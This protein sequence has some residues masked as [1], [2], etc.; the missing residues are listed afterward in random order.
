MTAEPT[1]APDA[2]TPL[3]KALVAIRQ[4]REKVHHLQQAAT[5]PIAIVGM[6]CRLPGADDPE[7]FWELLSDGRDMI[8][9]IPAD[10]WDIGA[11]YDPKPGQ[12]GKTYS[13]HG[14]FLSGVDR[15]D[16]AFF[17]ISAR[18]AE[19]MDPQQRL[20]LEV[21]WEALEHAGLIPERLAG[22]ATGV[23]IGVTSSD[24]GL[25]QVERATQE[26]NNPY[27]N[28]GTP[29]NA[30]AGRLSYILG[31]QGPCIAVDT[32]CSSSLSAIHLACA[33][34]RAGE[35]DQALAG[36]VNLILTPKLYVTL[37]A[38]GMLSPDGR[39]KTFDA[40]ANGYVRGEGCGIVI[41]KRYSDAQAAGDPI[42]AVIRGSVVNQDGASSGFTVPNGL[43]QQKLIREALA[44]AGVEPAAI[45]Y[46]EAHGTGTSLGDLIEAQAL[47]TVL[48]QP[49]GGG[50]ALLVGSVKSNI[51]HLESAAGVAG[52]IK[53][54][55]ALRHEQLPP[56]LHVSSPN[57]GVAWESLKV[58]PVLA[59]TPWPRG[60]K[61]RLAGLSSFGASG[62]NAH[63]IVEEAPPHEP[64]RPEQDRPVHVLALS[65][66]SAPAL[67]DLAA[68]YRRALEQAPT[69]PLADLCYSANSTRTQFKQ[70]A[71]LC[72]TDAVQACEQLA[73]LHEDRAAPGLVKG[74]ETPAK[75]PRVAFLFSGQGALHAGAGRTLYESHPGF[76]Q[77]M[78]T[79]A[80]IVAPLLERPLLSVLYPRD[81]ADA[82]GGLLDNARYAQP[83][84]FSLQYALASLWGSWG[85]APEA[86][87][88]H[89]LG[90]YCAAC[91]AGV[92]S[93]EDGLGLV[94]ER[95]RLMQSLPEQ[96]GMLAVFDE[97]PRVAEALAAHPHDL[98][99]AA[100]N[101]PRSVVISGRLS[102][103][104]EVASRLREQGIATAPLK[105]THA[106][107]S[108]VM[109]PILEPL[110]RFAAQI[111]FRPATVPLVSNLSGQVLPPG[112]VLDAAYWRRHCGEPVQFARGLS[113]LIEQ[114]STLFIELGA[115]PV[116]TQLGKRQEPS[117][118]W[119]PSLAPPRN[120]W[121][122]LAEGAA[123]AY[124]GGADIDWPGFDAGFP[125]NRISVATYPFQRK[126]YWFD[127]RGSAMQI[128]QSV[129][130]P[131]DD[132]RQVQRQAILTHLVQL[133]S[134]MLRVAPA[135]LDLQTSFLEMGADSLVL[136]EG[137]RLVADNFGVNL[138]MRQ[139]FEE[140]TTITSL[141]D[142]L[143]DRTTF[144][145]S[146]AKPSASV[147]AE[148][149]PEP[150][151]PRAVPASAAPAAPVPNAVPAPA[152]PVMQPAL[153]A[154]AD[155]ASLQAIVLAQMQLMSQQLALLQGAPLAAPQNQTAANATVTA[156][157]PISVTAPK[158]APPPPAAPNVASAAASEDRSSPLRALA[159]PIAPGSAT[160]RNPRQ[161]Q[162]LAA[163]VE[164][165]QRK[166]PRS[167]AL[168]EACRR[169]LADSR[170]S[171]GFRFSTKEIL[172]PI[173]GAE[174]LGSH[175]R[176][177]DGNT[178][179]DMTMGFGVLLFG[180]RP[181][182]M[183]GVIEEEIQ[184]GFQLGPRS[185]LMQEVTELFTELTG[186]DRVAFTNSGTEAIM[187]AVRLARAATGRSKIAMFEGSYH[188]H[189][190]GTLAKT[191]HV[192][193]ELRS[194]PLAPGVP[195][196]VAKDVLVLEYGTPETLEI[197][198]GHAHE[199]AA[200]L[201]EP[202][203]SRRLDFQPAEFLRQVRALTEES[204]TALIFDEMI[205]GFRAHPGGTQGLFGIE[206]DIAT[207]GKI[208]GGGMPIGAVAGK[209]R[210]LDGIDG[211]QWQY[212][213][214]SY[215]SVTRTY[216][217]GT[218]CQHPFAMAACRTA[219]RHLK[220][221]GPDLQERLNRRTADLAK[222]LNDYFEQESLPLRITYFS[223]AF[224]LSFP[225]NL[226]LIYYHLLEKG[227]YIWE[228]RNCFLSTAHTDEDIAF[229]IQAIKDSVEELRQGGFLPEAKSGRMT[230]APLRAA[231]AIAPPPTL[232]DRPVPANEF[233]V[234]HKSTP[235]VVA[236][237]ARERSAHQSNRAPVFGL[238]Y[239]GQYAAGF[240]AG[241]YD[242]IVESARYADRAG[243][244]ALWIP[245]RHFHEFGGFSPNPAVMAAALA[246]ETE[247]IQLRAGSVVLPLHDPIRVAEE[248]SVVDN[249]SDGRVGIA[250]ASGW[251]A[252]DFVFA[253]DAYGQHREL[254]FTGMR[255]VQQLWRGEK[256]SRRAGQNS[257]VEVGIYPRPKQ[258][259]LPAWLTIVNNPE[260][261]RAAGKAGV[262]VLTNLMAQSLD[263]L[264]ANIAIYREALAEHGHDPAKAN[265]TVLIHTYLEDDA[266]RA[267]ATA[268]Q[269]MCEYLL[270]SIGLF[271]GMAQSDGR[272]VDVGRL[273]QSDRTYLVQNA[274][275][276]YVAS[277]ALIGSPDT[278][279]PVVERLIGAGVDELA[280]FVDFGVD[281]AA[282]LRGLRHLSE[283]RGRYL[284]GEDAIGSVTRISAETPST[285]PLSEAQRQLWVLARLSP[286]GSRAYND[287]A[288]LLLTG[289]LDEPSLRQA[290]D[291]VAARHESLRTAFD[292][293]GEHQIVRPA[294]SI[295]LTVTDFS[296][297]ADPEARLRE[298]LDEQTGHLFDLAQGPLFQ[299]QL[300][301]LQAER[302]VIVL[303]THHIVSDGPSMGVI[304]D[305]L[306]T[307]YE[308][309]CR[310]QHAEL[311]APLQ[312]RD[313]V[314]W[315]AE[316]R[317]ADTMA[318]HEAYWLG[319]FAQP[320]AALELPTD[321]PRPA[322]RT[323]NGARERHSIEPVLL[324]S[325]RKAGG[326][327]GCT[328]YMMFL[329]VFSALLHRLSGQDAMTIGCPYTG[330]G[331]AGS[332]A[333]VGY[334]IHL[335]PVTST[336]TAGARFADHLRQVRDTLLDAFEH[337][338][339][340]FARLIDKLNL[341][342]GS[343]H[344][345]LLSVI[346]NLER[347][348]GAQT[349]AGLRIEPYDLPI[350]FTRVDL[351]LT[352]LL[353]DDSA[354]LECDYNSDLFDA[355][356]IQRLL[357]QYRGLLEAVTA[358]P[359]QSLATLP[360]L[361]Q[362][363][364]DTQVRASNDTGPAAPAACFHALWQARVA[365][366]PDGI[367][368]A[369]DGT[370]GASVTYGELNRRAN[371]LAHHLRRLGVGPDQRV[372]ICLR[373]N[374]HLMV[375]LLATLKAGGAFVPLDPAY[376]A[377]R[378]AM[379]QQDSRIAV[380]LTQEDLLATLPEHDAP[381]CCVDR[382]WGEIA[383]ES[384]SDPDMNTLPGNLAYVIYTSGSTGKPK[385]V[386][387]THRGL[388]NYLDWAAQTYTSP[389]G[390]GAPVL[391]SIGFDA[392]ITSLFVPLLSG[393]PVVLLTEGGE[394]EALASLSR[395]QRMFDFIKLTPA[396]LELFNTMLG[397]APP[398]HL[399]HRLVLGGEALQSATINPWLQH[400]GTHAVNEYGPTETVV[401]C[402][403]HEASSPGS[404][405]VPIGRPIQ[406]A[407]LYVLDRHLQV[408]P[409]G[410]AGE[411]YIGGAG[412]AR[413]YLDRAG[414]TAAAFI[415]DP[416]A[417]ADGTAGARVY[418]TGDRARY[419]PDGPLMF[420]GRIDRQ[421]KL[422]GVRIELGEI[423]AVLTALPAVQEAAVL[424]REDQPGQ[425]HLVAYVR[426]KPDH[427]PGG[428]TLR[429]TLKELLP[430]H[431]VPA[432]IVPVAEMPLTANG[433]IDRSRLP[434]PDRI[435]LQQTEAYA[436]PR[437]DIERQLAESW[438]QVLDVERVG[439]HD[440]FFDLGGNSFLLL[441]ACSKLPH[442]LDRETGVIE[443]FRYPTIAS[444]AHH[445][446]NG[447][448]QAPGQSDYGH[449]QARVSQQRVAAQQQAARRRKQRA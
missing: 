299:A 123:Q 142:Y 436:S 16:A 103:L 254:T 412:L 247:R 62:S 178:Y 329:A 191:V 190:D 346:F 318:R 430:H 286:D 410:V 148:R 235:N 94:A 175:L 288:A 253:P 209:R 49:R 133:I 168:A 429:E 42:L 160:S 358:D 385:G 324:A 152:A 373:R 387:V 241:K 444:L 71:A 157:A 172:Y 61:R 75:P 226:E 348:S 304:F 315:Q 378:L 305:E 154:Q 59:P 400:T 255:T 102:A 349:R 177:V 198:R 417:G 213:D 109:D 145:L 202:V 365:Q 98:S 164:R 11:H 186:H 14:G 422:H 401:G 189:S 7:T 24:Y 245:E 266:G 33:S 197:L 232:R 258:A 9:E 267:I 45:D 214:N 336:A 72:M 12:P 130:P 146:P 405:V 320:V 225:G 415:P 53:L 159:T 52:L 84:L 221:Q 113:A 116:L 114:G 134:N 368:L 79:C 184:R 281:R 4:L 48:G 158:P 354:V 17:G 147:T 60:A 396:H 70:R 399:A 361:T 252:S 127:T 279:A 421:I 23:F 435:R 414:L 391:G 101:G 82:A 141:A 290:L 383:R 234:P 308:A 326:A 345:P 426:S 28:T 108:P 233:R 166:T 257:T 32:A 418:K 150:T 27:F 307:L 263:E 215:P 220:A 161:D 386:M 135:E 339:Y 316:Q 357:D 302:H 408:L 423:E 180:N 413:G 276:K 2:L 87:L 187:I 126:S 46:V 64:S 389:D 217:G 407:R 283:L 360:L 390:D 97:A 427:A 446:S 230:I 110:E 419:L 67:R 291:E 236:L 208:I 229:F 445:L 56:S 301:R 439:I 280:C 377:A 272:A 341:E 303:L 367:A 78:D 83:A 31:F 350:G 388:V 300:Y 398:A 68:R 20:L 58:R 132:D 91:V 369:D 171:V 375:A 441:Q 347:Y 63:L 278:C 155:P 93:V 372:G 342:R 183:N 384:A 321:H 248:W 219:L 340:P 287:P 43:A 136:V 406:G 118:A 44:K 193:G 85:I 194:E 243:F 47:G 174:A 80:E 38:A 285:Y 438:Q 363:A 327:H 104:K 359:N 73:A 425:P 195:A 298:V 404:G 210:F 105:V 379:M 432:A 431:M 129:S 259:E 3:Q 51:G 353:R 261:Y 66:K 323:F 143:V 309:A 181:D 201:V 292:P 223:S 200:V 364:R 188:G 21:A 55:Q 167:K 447:Q 100:V 119:M 35:C 449:I 169:G 90:E 374:G 424:L 149:A 25:L 179:L 312:Y 22:S 244:H 376:P 351:T 381:V 443:F 140:V 297:E 344:P 224:R 50:Q 270:S 362:A 30:C 269:P 313:F 204:G 394:L 77:T 199:L 352:V 112:S 416:F 249:L 117:L 440:N 89:S 289:R 380:L 218:F 6:G 314:R 106:F 111:D 96:G 434:A 5:E 176:D 277:S 433:K 332:N 409:P 203:Q 41:L 8:T 420:L 121:S 397:D 192:D 153:A 325:V 227:V 293:S 128:E 170:A 260:T 273:S 137:M 205:T 10:R 264:A 284:R 185:D 411:L 207:Y 355:A 317:H 274:Y 216:F 76:R 328:P 282:V 86:V 343:S 156:V 294:G 13:R 395:S 40:S 437:S 107:H 69:A 335:L 428:D 356:S 256:I 1:G 392:T 251:H 333:L 131:A 268:R 271:Q 65:A 212:G 57:P 39:C 26:Q 15:F 81:D 366:H 228:W 139:F 275:E 163:L 120:D 162:H 144:G 138:E 231:G 311:P 182:F 124:V 337:Q 196:N 370:D 92:F 95:G 310:G 19:G 250:F 88:G 334:C 122:V 442:L 239:F 37:S 265:V 242:L 54:V 36:G 125:R 240:T 115:S 371:R 173:T 74:R 296:A 222:T 238:A 382:D 330:R 403:V 338:D 393:H 331:L 99:I 18:E 262:G 448:G 151:P 306:M 206:A 211:G 295:D 34:L 246:R 165:Y 237:P 402:C 319:Q 29:L 322:V